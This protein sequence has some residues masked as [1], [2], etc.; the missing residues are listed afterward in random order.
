MN[1]HT[2]G[3]W[4]V[5]KYSAK[6]F[7]LGKT[8]SGAFFFLQCVNDDADKPQAKAD[9]RLI[10]SAHDLLETLEQIKAL[11]EVHCVD[12]VSRREK[13]ASIFMLSANVISKATQ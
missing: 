6:R 3:P 11:S 7:G 10:A 4:S 2:S 13:L 8:G 12:D 9:A 5:A 1:T